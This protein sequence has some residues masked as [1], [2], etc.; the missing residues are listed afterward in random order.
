MSLL[1]QNLPRL[2]VFTTVIQSA[3]L[4]LAPHQVEP[5][6]TLFSLL[7]DQQAVTA[8]VPV[9]PPTEPPPNRYVTAGVG[10]SGGALGSLA[11]VK[12]GTAY[13][14]PVGVIAGQAIIPF[15][16]TFI[17]H[18][19]ENPAKEVVEHFEELFKIHERHDSEVGV[20]VNNVPAVMKILAKSLVVSGW[21]EQ[22]T[23]AEFCLPD[24]QP[25]AAAP[26][27]LS[28]MPVFNESQS[29]YGQA[30]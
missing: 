4:M 18:H 21:V 28:C 6:E 3:H 23:L 30:S 20:R 26:S 10:F 27:A 25:R 19:E 24:P 17:L 5:N 11:L 15:M 12:A 7:F 1:P 13:G 8:L 22:A 29:H 16:S 2:G 14:G 9:Q